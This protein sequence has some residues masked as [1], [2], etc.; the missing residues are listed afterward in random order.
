MQ[1]ILLVRL[2][3]TLVASVTISTAASGQ[4]FKNH[5]LNGLDPSREGGVWTMTLREGLCHS[6]N[7]GDGRGESDCVNGNLRSQLQGRSSRIGRTVEYAFD[8][9]VPKNFRYTESLSY[10]KRG[11]IE[12]AGWQHTRAIKNHLYEMHLTGR[13]VTFEDRV[14][15]DRSRFGQ[16][17]S[18]RVRVTWSL[19]Q[20]GA[21]QILCNG[22]QVYAI[23][24][25]TLIP[26]GCGTSA[27]SNCHSDKLAHQNP[28]TWIVGPW[29]RGFGPDWKDYGRSSPFLPFPTNGVSIKIRNLYQGKLR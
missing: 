7:Y 21:L 17:N 9:M 6:G 13:A 4:G 25:Q 16:W 18:V 22:K 23:E 12:I 27:K 3:L 14:C 1:R 15:F 8:I 28:I 5:E 10:R 19:G 20:D 11:S 29:Y 26:P 24:G 2:L